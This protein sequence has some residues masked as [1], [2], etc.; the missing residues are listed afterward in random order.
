MNVSQDRSNSLN[1]FSL[2]REAQRTN[3]IEL[4]AANCPYDNADG[5][6]VTP[7]SIFFPSPFG[8]YCNMT[9]KLENGTRVQL[10]KLGEERNQRATSKTGI[11]VGKTRGYGYYVVMDG[12]I[13]RSI[14]HRTYIEPILE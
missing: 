2:K 14:F 5:R 1:D 10:T 8:V 12:N 3:E 7:L 11:V 6:R 13:T 9:G 4:K